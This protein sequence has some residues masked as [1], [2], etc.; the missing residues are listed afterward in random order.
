M[1][2][3]RTNT[4]P[5]V[6]CDATGISGLYFLAMHACTIVFLQARVVRYAALFNEFLPT[7][8][9]TFRFDCCHSSAAYDPRLCHH[10]KKR[11][12]QSVARPVTNG[13]AR[14]TCQ[15]LHRA[16]PA[17]HDPQS[18]RPNTRPLACSCENV[19]TWH[20]A[21][22]AAAAWP[23]CAGRHP[24]LGQTRHAGFRQRGPVRWVIS[25]RN[26]VYAQ[27]LQC[28]EMARIPAAIRRTALRLA[29]SARR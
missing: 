2:L 27:R 21:R 11:R 20:A 14:L 24:G 3:L 6:T 18:A 8:T 17:A 19:V 28:I 7:N 25:R 4:P 22:H 1:I 5:L 13:A 29:L 16:P 9:S 12:N 15:Q 26:S 23:T 10:P